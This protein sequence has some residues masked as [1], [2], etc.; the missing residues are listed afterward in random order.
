MFQNHIKASLIQKKIWTTSLFTETA[1]EASTPTIEDQIFTCKH[2]SLSAS[3]NNTSLDTW[4]GFQG[5][6][7]NGMLGY[8]P[9]LRRCDT[10]TENSKTSCECEQVLML[11]YFGKDNTLLLQIQSNFSA[12]ETILQLDW[13]HNDRETDKRSAEWQEEIRQSWV[14]AVHASWRNTHDRLW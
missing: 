12:L 7:K 14:R 13:K 5:E 2:Q 4:G 6:Q 3:K 9:W 11:T 10:L 8:G 1:S